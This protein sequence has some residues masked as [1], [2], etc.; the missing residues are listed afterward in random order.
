MVRAVCTLLL[1]LGFLLA[2]SEG[3]EP[4]TGTVTESLEEITE[5]PE[6]KAGERRSGIPK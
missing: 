1:S 2:C 3:T 6:E 5:N 4:N